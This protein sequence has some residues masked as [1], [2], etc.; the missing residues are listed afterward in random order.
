MCDHPYHTGSTNWMPTS[1]TIGKQ[2]LKCCVSY[3][4]YLTELLPWNNVNKAGIA[5]IE[6]AEFT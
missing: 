2:L 1:S 3:F 5:F 4:A 6:V